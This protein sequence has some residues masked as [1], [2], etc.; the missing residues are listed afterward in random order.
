MPYLFYFTIF[1]KV[2]IVIFIMI[3]IVGLFVFCYWVHNFFLMITLTI[4]FTIFVKGFC[5]DL[6]V[7]L[8]YFCLGKDMR[9]IVFAFVPKTKQVPYFNSIWSCFF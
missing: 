1:V 6:C 5:N 3:N 9:I 4:I 2:C 8:I 7:L